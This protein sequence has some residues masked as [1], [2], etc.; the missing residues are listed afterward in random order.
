VIS[1]QGNRN[2]VTPT[3]QQAMEVAFLR[4]ALADPSLRPAQRLHSAAALVGVTL[5]FVEDAAP[6]AP[7]IHSAWWVGTCGNCMP[8]CRGGSQLSL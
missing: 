7:F 4:R 1:N 5:F 6:R 2:H 8:P 3:P